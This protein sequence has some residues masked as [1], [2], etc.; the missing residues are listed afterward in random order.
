MQDNK[1]D[2]L[3]ILLR[4]KK[5]RSFMDEDDIWQVWG[6]NNDSIMP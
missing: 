1:C 2:L 3:S 5:K 6:Q 4:N